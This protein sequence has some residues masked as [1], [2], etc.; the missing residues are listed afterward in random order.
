MHRIRVYHAVLAVL[1]LLAYMTGDDDA[2]HAWLGYGVAGV[3]VFRLLWVFSGNPSVGLMRFYPS[4][5]G[6][7]LSN[8]FSHP[9]I[10]KTFMLGIAFSLLSVTSTGIMMD[11]GKSIGLADLEV[12]A[13]AFADDEE[14]E[15]KNPHK[16]EKSF[17]EE[18]LED[19]H[20]FFGNLL[21]VFV[22]FHVSYL[23]LFKRPLAKFML[24]LPKKGRE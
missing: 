17:F 6:L 21:L 1:A 16:V 4:F 9:A 10:T 23:I 11:Q 15:R 12:V 19:I 22:G 2:S 13:P 7:N 3:I 8:A 18:A 14:R 20:E 5:A 24:F